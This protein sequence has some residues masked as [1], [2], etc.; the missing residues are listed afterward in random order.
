MMAMGG[1]DVGMSL[2]RALELRLWREATTIYMT[3]GHGGCGP[4]G[5]AVAA[6][7]RGF[8]A[9]VRAVGGGAEGL[10]AD[11]VR[12]ADKKAV[13][14]LVEES[15]L[16]ELAQAGA[17]VDDAPLTVEELE[18]ALR[19]GWAGL[20]LVSAYRLSGGKAPHWVTL[21]AIDERY[22]YVHEPDMDPA[23]SLT[24]TDC[25]GIPIPRED[26]ARMMRYGRARQQAALF[27][28]PRRS[29]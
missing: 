8:E 10:F 14:R 18:A 23:H 12:D 11:S 21:A 29:V 24:A 26:F 28:R 16:A 1:F 19:A 7:A 20:V 27:L 15:F 22:V 25:M 4:H 13:I 2:D 3:S 5:L 17:S 9:R 6:L